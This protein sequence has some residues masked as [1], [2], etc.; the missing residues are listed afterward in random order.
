MG[1]CFALARKLATTR[2]S[3]AFCE[4]L[5]DLAIS[6]AEFSALTEKSPLIS[7]SSSEP[8]ALKCVSVW[9]L[10]G[11][12][13]FLV[14][15]ACFIADSDEGR[16][17]E[18]VANLGNEFSFANANALSAINS[19]QNVLGSCLI[20]EILGGA[21]WCRLRDVSKS[22]ALSLEWGADLHRPGQG[23]GV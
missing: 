20:N 1:L 14:A 19:D 10:S 16:A 18:R 13:D 5:L 8:G 23:G 7:P 9:A 6:L 2:A 4:V 11:E 17:V 22:S 15:H 21:L 3:K 12:A